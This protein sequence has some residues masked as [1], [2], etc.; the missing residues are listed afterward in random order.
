VSTTSDRPSDRAGYAGSLPAGLPPSDNGSLPPHSSFKGSHRA[1]GAYVASL[2]DQLSTRDEAILRGLGRV[3]CLTGRQLER[4]HFHDL[5]AANRD[6]AR[7]RVL[8]HLIHLS[9]ITTLSRRIGGVRAGSA[10]LVYALD[11][12]GQRLVQLL[13]HEGDASA[14][15]PW[16][17]SALFLNHT[18][19]VS[20]LFV[21]LCE[22]ERPGRLELSIFLAEPASWHR[23]TAL[24]TLKPDAY[25]LVASGDVEDAWWLE[26]DQATESRNTIRRKLSLYV[27]AA[28]AGVTGPDGILPR[29]LVTVPDEK[30][31]TVVREIVSGLGPMAERLIF[32]TLHNRAVEYLAETLH[33]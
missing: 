19:A 9:L 15:R 29:V 16:T 14:R 32:A 17:P 7:R 1:T 27:L 5:Q 22:A 26:V 25:A 23:T 31:A 33:A 11:A 10:G 6:R 30:R 8:S 12:A 28:Q 4:L 18:L 3:R 24:G 2:V 13:N 21:S 20:E